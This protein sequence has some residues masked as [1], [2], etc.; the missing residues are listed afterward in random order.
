VPQAAISHAP[1]AATAEAFTLA[2]RT[3]GV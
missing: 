1:V 2:Q 3:A